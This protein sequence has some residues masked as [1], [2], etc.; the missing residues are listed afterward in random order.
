MTRGLI[1]ISTLLAPLSL[2]SAQ[3]AVVAIEGGVVH[4]GTGEVLEGA[5]VLTQGRKIVAVGAGLEI[6]A[7]AT[8]L[9]A[10]GKH[11]YP[12]LIDADTVLGLVEIG[13]VQATIDTQEVGAL[14]PNLRAE[15]AVNPDSELLPVARTGGVLLALSAPRSGTI[16]GTSALIYTQG[17]TWEDMTVRAPVS[18]LVRWPAMRVDRSG[19]AK[20]SADDQREQREER[21]HQLEEAFSDARAY[22]RARREQGGDGPRED[23]KWEALRPV[24]NGSLPVTVLADDVTQL[25]AALD[26]AER[27]DLRLIVAGG[28]D[29]W[30]LADELAQRDIPVILGPVQSLPRRSYEGLDTPFRNAAVLREAGVRIAFS[31]GGSAFAAA[32]ARNLRL[33]AAQAAA[34]GLPR[35]AAVHALTL[36]AAAILGVANR[37]GSLEPDKEAT[38]FVADG[39]ILEAATK[40]EAAWVAGQPVGLVDRQQKLYERYRSRPKRD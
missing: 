38:L 4:V 1:L 40:L 17:W 24:F 33:Q 39:D 22:D 5:T 25:R 9:N 34:Y 26:W 21:L 35:E 11:V 16:P 29:A 18:L 12:G 15:L 7:G 36:G 28:A 3:S 37:L 23:P 14:N 10:T 32:N 13:A 6:P 30:R 8:R 27:F 31:T 20:K 19:R 2:A